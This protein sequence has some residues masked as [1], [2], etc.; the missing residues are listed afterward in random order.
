MKGRGGGRPQRDHPGA[1]PDYPS[2]PQGSRSLRRGDGRD[3]RVEGPNADV[4]DRR[5]GSVSTRYDVLVEVAHCKSSTRKS[6]RKWK[7]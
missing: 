1:T 7:D 6:S 4:A 5:A 2:G 3:A